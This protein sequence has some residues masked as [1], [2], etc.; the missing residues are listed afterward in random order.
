MYYILHTTTCVINA[1]MMLQNH[2]QTAGPF[3]DFQ[4]SHSQSFSSKHGDHQQD[5]EEN[6][7]LFDTEAS[8]LSD[9]SDN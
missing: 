4:C 7:V 8:E 2:V 1:L 3:S 9:F 6:E 5:Y